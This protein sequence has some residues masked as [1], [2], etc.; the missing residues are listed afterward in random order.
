MASNY[1]RY[2]TTGEYVIDSGSTASD[3]GDWR[4]RYEPI[5]I[6]PKPEFTF[7]YK[8]EPVQYYTYNDSD[9]KIQK[10]LRIVDDLIGIM[11]CYGVISRHKHTI[12]HIRKEIKEL[13]EMQWLPEP[14]MQWVPKEKKEEKHLE[15]E[16]FEI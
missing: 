6:E 9:I 10:L 11:N 2:S 15:E 16:L 1:G 12:K 3:A 14:E 5:P 13:Q 8:P 7:E 4:I